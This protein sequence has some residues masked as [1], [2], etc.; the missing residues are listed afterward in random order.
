M[1][2]QEFIKKRRYLV[3]YVKEPENLSPESIVEAVLNYGNW[4]D[5]QTL[6]KIMGIKKVAKIFRE[7]S[8]PSKMGRQNYRSETKNYFGLYFN[9]YA[10]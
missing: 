1:T 2:I 6:I 3:W 9:K 5:V 7:K 8:K 4:D 10:K